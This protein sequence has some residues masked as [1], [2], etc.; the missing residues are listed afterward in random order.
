MAKDGKALEKIVY[1]I[2]NALKDTAQT[3]IFINH[4]LVNDSGERREFDIII[5]IS[6]LKD[7]T[8]FRKQ[9]RTI[10]LGNH[11]KRKKGLHA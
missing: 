3:K 4:K 5:C 10:K 9:F 6:P 2:Q 7:W 1:L 8:K 11:E